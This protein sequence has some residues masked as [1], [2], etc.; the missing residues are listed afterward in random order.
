MSGAVTEMTLYAAGTQM[1][2]RASRREWL[3]RRFGIWIAVTLRALLPIL[4]SRAHLYSCL[5]LAPFNSSI[6]RISI[7]SQRSLQ[8]VYSSSVIFGRSE[9]DSHADTT[10]L[11]KNSI[12]LNF[13]GREFEV[14]PYADS[15]ESIKKVLIVTGATGYTSPIYGKRLILI[16]N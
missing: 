14:S 11:G 16:F 13:T 9:I 6:S 12:I 3:I 8:R 2:G 7:V 1:G 4:Q 15:Y 5:T 10:T